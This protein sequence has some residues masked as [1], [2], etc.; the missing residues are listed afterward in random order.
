[1]D[2]KII[3]D[4]LVYICTDN[5]IFSLVSFLSLYPE[6]SVILRSRIQSK[7]VNHCGLMGHSATIPSQMRSKKY[8]I[9]TQGNSVK[10][11]VCCKAFPHIFAVQD[12]LPQ[13]HRRDESTFVIILA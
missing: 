8:D 7:A 2:A 6:D 5:S 3:V 1:M 11:E 13:K 10:F 12:S 4:D 9:H